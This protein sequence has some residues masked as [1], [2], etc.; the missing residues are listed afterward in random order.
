[1]AFFM[2]ISF[3]EDAS[4]KVSDSDYCQDADPVFR[5]FLFFFDWNLSDHSS[6]AVWVPIAFHFWSYRIL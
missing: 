5:F 4:L 2:N 1:M 6:A 3:L